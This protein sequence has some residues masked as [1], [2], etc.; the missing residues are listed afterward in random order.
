[1]L[2]ETNK[3]TVIRVQGLEYLYFG[4]TNYLGL[5]HRPELLEAAV[6]AFADFGFSCSASRVTS[7]TNV[8]LQSLEE[9][10]AAFAKSDAA[11]TLTAGFMSN[12]AVVQGID[13]QVNF[14]VAAKRAHGSIKAA[15]QQ[16]SRPAVYYDAH[17]ISERTSFREEF[18]LP[19]DCTLGVFLEAVDALSGELTNVQALISKLTDRD[20]FIIDEAHSFGVLGRG[21]L[22]IIDELKPTDDERLIRTG[23][24]SKAIGTSGGFVL[25]RREIIDQIKNESAAYVASTPLSP[26]ICAATRESLRLIGE[27][28]ESTIDRLSANIGAMNMALS[29]IGLDQ[30]SVHRTPIYLLSGLPGT[31]EL[32]AALSASGICIPSVG[33]YF[34]NA[35]SMLRWT[36]QAGHT[37]EQLEQLTKEIGDFIVDQQT[38]KLH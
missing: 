13:S 29:K 5:S 37:A 9:E 28:P 36:I 16:S 34:S 27:E 32:G 11:L 25:C 22:G 21:D 17:S 7:G 1:M 3:S 20:Y 6:K 26:V 2:V 19:E 24:F 31:A 4:G 18:N 38:R 15:V 14:W 35:D 33:S 23:T 8:L 30:F 10:L 12:T